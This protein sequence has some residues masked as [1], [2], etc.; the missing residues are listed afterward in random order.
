[1]HDVLQDCPANSACCLCYNVS[2]CVG[3]RFMCLKCSTL[4]ILVFMLLSADCRYLSDDET[5]GFSRL[6]TVHLIMARRLSYILC[7]RNWCNWSRRSNWYVLCACGTSCT[8][9]RFSAGVSWEIC[10]ILCVFL[11]TV[12]R[13]RTY[14]ALPSNIL[15]IIDSEREWEQRVCSLSWR[16]GCCAG[17]FHVYLCKIDASTQIG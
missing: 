15:D 2:V 16:H 10:D 7:R 8:E 6:Q 14:I 11:Y 5:F 12:V 9:C 17:G 3:S 1:M 13:L 4:F